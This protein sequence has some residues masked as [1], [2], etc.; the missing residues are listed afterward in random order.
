MAERSKRICMYDEEKLKH[1]NSETLKLFQKYQV[2][3]SIRDLSPNTING[4][5][6]DLQQWFIFMYDRQ[7][8]LSVLECTDDDLN[9]YFYFRKQ[10][11]NNVNR[12]RRVMSSISAFL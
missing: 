9:E 10:E 8:N 6:S 7:F 4:Y 1:I 3:M 12:Q 2:D 5:I 11:G